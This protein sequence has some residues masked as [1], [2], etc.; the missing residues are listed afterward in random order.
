MSGLKTH[1][2][3]LQAGYKVSPDE[4]D[5]YK[6]YV[7]LNPSVSASYFGT[8]ASAAAVAITA[9][10]TR[11]T[12]PRNVLLSVTG[13]AGGMGGTAVINGKD[14]FGQPVTETLGF[15]SAAGGGTVAGTKIF[16]TYTSGTFT[17]QGLGGTAVGTVSLGFQIGTSTT[18]PKF[19]LP[20]KL[21]AT[22][23]IKAVAWIDADV[24]K[25]HDTTTHVDLAT[26]SIRIEVAGG[27][28]AADSFVVWYKPSKDLSSEGL[29]AQI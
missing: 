24:E 12:Y 10:N 23:D 26:N 21:G 3:A 5:Q 2:P 9:I 13:V 7:I 17:P 11:T 18:G 6:Q 4:I 22:S 28:A 20:D 27:V 25:Q 29:Q 16:A 8:A 19:G 14:Q 1:E 15:G